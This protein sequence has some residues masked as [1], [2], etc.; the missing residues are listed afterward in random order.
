MFFYKKLYVSDSLRKT[1]K[2]VCWNL[3]HNR[4]Q[5]DI[6]VIALSMG[7][8]LF[9]IFHCANMKQKNFNRNDLHIIGIAKGYDE[10]VELTSRIVSDYH[11]KYGIMHFKEQFLQKEIKNFRR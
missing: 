11:H 5:L 6:Y 2:K 9:D 3:K 7:N 8:D 1:Y 4:G 10:A